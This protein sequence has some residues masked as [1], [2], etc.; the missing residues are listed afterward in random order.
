MIPLNAEVSVMNHYSVHT[1]ELQSMDEYLRVHSNLSRYWNL[2]RKES[3]SYYYN[4]NM[5]LNGIMIDNDEDFKITSRTVYD[6]S[7]LA[8]EVGGF[9]STVNLILAFLFPFIRFDSLETYLISRLFKQPHKKPIETPSGELSAERKLIVMT[10]SS[11][12]LRQP[13]KERTRN[14]IIEFFKSKGLCLA[15]FLYDRQDYN[16]LKSRQKLATELDI[17]RI[18]KSLRY[19]RSTVR[20]LT[21][22]NERRLLRLQANYTVADEAKNTPNELL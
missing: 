14:P 5:M 22:S 10:Q 21:N 8:G 15:P 7:D 6:L 17:K 12:Q 11:V 9:A 3:F 16:Y 18:L 19:L 4:P 2:L 20:F 13:I 1:E